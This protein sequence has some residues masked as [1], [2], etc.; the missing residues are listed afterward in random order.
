MKTATKISVTPVNDGLFYELQQH[1][2][3][4]DK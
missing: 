4:Y 3:T 2:H 1:L